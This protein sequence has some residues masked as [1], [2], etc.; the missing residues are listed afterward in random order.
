MSLTDRADVWLAEKLNQLGC[1]NIGQLSPAKCKGILK[2]DIAILLVGALTYMSRQSD[3]IRDK[4]NT[5]SE[6][7]N[8]VI[9]SQRSVIELQEQLIDSK[10][11]QLKSVERTVKSS[12]QET[13][14]AEFQTYS[15]AVQKGQSVSPANL[16]SVVKEVVE[17]EDRSRNIMVF[18]LKEEENELLGTKVSDVLQTI[19]EKPRIEVC[20]VGKRDTRQPGRA[21]KVT[22]SSSVTVNQILSKARNLRDSEKHKDVYLS[23]D[24][25]YEQR[26]EHRLLVVELKKVTADEPSKRHFIR[27]GK[28]CSIAKT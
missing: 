4:S 8:E 9:E 20:R 26:T 16:K 25:S 22:L 3:V 19:G 6:L 12:V 11:E 17:E 10:N 15:S 24:R 13:V 21:V 23:A 28:V 1:V 18:G 27:N 5:V 2:D 14:K 7:R